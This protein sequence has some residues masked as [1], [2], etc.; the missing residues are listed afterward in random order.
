M[1]S[2]NPVS[3]I[4]QPPLLLSCWDISWSWSL[5]YQVSRQRPANWYQ[6]WNLKCVQ[7]GGR[8][9]Q[10]VKLKHFGTNKVGVASEKNIWPGIIGI[11]PGGQHRLQKLI[12]APIH[13]NHQHLSQVSLLEGCWGNNEL[14][15]AP[16]LCCVVI[17]CCYSCW[18]SVTLI[19]IFCGYHY[20]YILL[21]WWRA[22]SRHTGDI[23][24]YGVVLEWRDTFVFLQLSS[25][26]WTFLQFRDRSLGV[27]FDK[28]GWAGLWSGSRH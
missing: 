28:T 6:T 21:C 23:A 25:I 3:I 10:R 7:G 15:V 11:I 13:C 20:R 18:Y 14:K 9:G 12:H 26:I 2:D 16:R 17:Y 4:H 8:N 5:F 19:L 24:L 27:R 1:S 22:R